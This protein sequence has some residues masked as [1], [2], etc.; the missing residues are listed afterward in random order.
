MR[1]QRER[2]ARP[3]DRARL[4]LCCRDLVVAPLVGSPLRPATG[5]R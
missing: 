2:R 4:Q 5:D 1:S 3:L